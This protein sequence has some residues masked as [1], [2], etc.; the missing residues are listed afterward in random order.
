MKETLKPGLQYEFKFQVPDSKTVPA[1]YPE[2]PEFQV[3]PKVLATGYLIGLL[4]GPASRRSIR[5]LTGP[6]SKLLGQ[7][8]GST[9]LLQHHPVLW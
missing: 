2:A 7:I 5:T 9:I 8:S 4:S 6:G 3:M 1:L